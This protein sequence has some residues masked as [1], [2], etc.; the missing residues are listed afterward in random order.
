MATTPVGLVFT[1]RFVS[2]AVT[3]YSQR[4]Q[5]KTKKTKRFMS[6]KLLF[7]ISKGLIGSYC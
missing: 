6:D 3:T 7:F 2:Y 4:V 5:R 1:F